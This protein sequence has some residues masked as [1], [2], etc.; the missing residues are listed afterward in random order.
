MLNV[1]TKDCDCPYDVEDQ[2]VFRKVD[3]MQMYCL[4]RS[5]WQFTKSLLRKR[6][7]LPVL[8][9]NIWIILVTA[10]IS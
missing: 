10:D 9:C 6:A 2:P 7:D 5:R 4:N 1:Q 3:L 8:M